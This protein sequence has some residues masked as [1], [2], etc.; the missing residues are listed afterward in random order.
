MRVG[1]YLRSKLGKFASLIVFLLA[2]VLFYSLTTCTYYGREV[3][4]GYTITNYDV[5]IEVD[6]NRTATV[7]ENILVDFKLPSHGIYRYIP[8]SHIQTYQD[9]DGNIQKKKVEYAIKDFEV[10]EGGELVDYDYSTTYKLYQFG[11]PSHTYTGEKNYKISYKVELGSDQDKIEDVFYFNINGEGIDTTIEHFTFSIKFPH[12]VEG[13][14][15]QF[16]VGKYNETYTNS[17][18]R[19]SLTI[20]GDTV[21]GSCDNLKPWEAVTVFNLFDEG[22]F[23][24]EYPAE[25][26]TFDIF[27][28]ITTIIIALAI[29]LL[30]ILKRRKDP[31]IE[32]VEFKAPEGMTPTEAGYINDGE[33]TGDDLSALIVYWANKGYVKIENE[34]ND[35]IIITKVK[36]LPSSAKEH[37]RILFTALFVGGDTVE[38]SSIGEDVG[39][40]GYK[41]KQSAISSCKKYFDKKP[42]RVFNVLSIAV[43]VMMIIPFFRTL[44]FAMPTL[45]FF[46]GIGL[47]GILGFAISNID[48]VVRLKDKLL[49]KKYAFLLAALLIGIIGPLIG[50]IFIVAPYADPWG[51]RFYLAILPLL[52]LLICPYLENYTKEGKDVLGHIRG[53]KSYILHAEKGMLEAL[54]YDNPSVYYEILPYAYVL[55]VSKVYMEK[56]QD[57]DVAQPDWYYGDYSHAIFVGHLFNCMNNISSNG[58]GRA[59]SSGGF[60]RGGSSGGGFFGGGSSGGGFS[61]GGSGGGGMGRW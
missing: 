55:G 11:D 13:E 28:I 31:I 48:D 57:I 24:L 5:A 22:F 10:L 26:H 54:V 14:D 29:V 38:S 3:D 9:K 17:D 16:Y 45:N 39:I 37:E 50:L 42:S 1:I 61:G 40:A 2:L 44:Q 21:A 15:F 47:L 34:S 18:E 19:V 27:I 49:N 20:S 7:K 58:F 12:N 41:S 52:L 53:L 43:I 8:Y 6:E 35:S 25:N 59:V 23:T 30:F 46:I 56:F 4:D 51:A 32:V 36:N 60:L 33:L